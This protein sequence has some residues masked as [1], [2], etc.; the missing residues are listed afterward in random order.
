MPVPRR[1]ESV[2]RLLL[3][4]AYREHVLGDLHE[5]YESPRQYVPD[6]LS[7]LGPVVISRIRRT[8]DFEV[9]LMEAFAIYL[10]YLAA[11]WYLGQHGFLYDGF[12]FERLAIPTALAVI[13]LLISNAYSDLEKQS[14]AKATMQAGGSLALAFLGQA[15]LFDTVRRLAVPFAVMLFG[16]CIGLVL[17]S[18]LRILFPPVERR[19][20]FAG[21]GQRRAAS[22]Q[23]SA[24]SFQLKRFADRSPEPSR[25]LFCAALIVLVILIGLSIW[26]R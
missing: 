12:G 26:R 10:S 7:V 8:T 18:T 15:A 25:R 16:S 22:V 6:A 11:A 23:S 2:V 24:F 14:P 1:I 13:G 9:L 3:P 4:P 21:P 17:V 5:R 20:N 19:P